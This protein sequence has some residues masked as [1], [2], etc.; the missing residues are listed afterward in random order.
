MGRQLPAGLSH[1]QRS[2]LSEFYTGHI[3][4]GQ[5]SQRLGLEATTSTDDSAQHQPGCHLPYDFGCIHGLTDAARQ[6][7]ADGVTQL[8]A[9]AATLPLLPSRRAAGSRYRAG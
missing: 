1:A 8:A 5:L 9:P 4:A 7:A 6:G 2:A 3:S